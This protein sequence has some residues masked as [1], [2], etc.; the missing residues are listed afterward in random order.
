MVTLI[1]RSIIK[2]NKFL[3]Y[4]FLSE[5]EE[6]IFAE[7]EKSNNE[8]LLCNL[9]IESMYL[10][11]TYWN[12]GGLNPRSG[13]IKNIEGIF[14]YDLFNHKIRTCEHSILKFT[15]EKENFSFEDDNEYFE[16]VLSK[17][18]IQLVNGSPVTID[19]KKIN[20]I[21]EVDLQKTKTGRIDR[22][23][24]VFTLI[25]TP[26]AKLTFP[27]DRGKLMY[28]DKNL[29]E[30]QDLKQDDLQLELEF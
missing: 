21:I 13:Y 2:G 25:N 5:D 6:K 11:Y 9:K 28:F 27:N 24:F 26:K 23:N 12:N 22:A 8:Y 1:K 15:K 17:A 18:I 16:K 30:I 10:M 4:L 7:K 29:L 14:F 20:E 3:P 19:P